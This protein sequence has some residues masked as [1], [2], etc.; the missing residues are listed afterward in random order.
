MGRYNLSLHNDSGEGECPIA[1][2]GG[3]EPGTGVSGRAAAAGRTVGC[4]VCAGAQ[5]LPDGAGAGA[6]PT[7]A[8]GV[9]QHGAVAPAE[10]GGALGSG[11]GNVSLPPHV[12]HTALEQHPSA[13]LCSNASSDIMS[14]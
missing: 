9:L 6:V 14:Q 10:G 3:L 13:V 7:G 4:D 12:S 2:S 8:D 11:A 5:V 1:G